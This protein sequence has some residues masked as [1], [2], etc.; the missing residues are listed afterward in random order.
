M[1]IVCT[2]EQLYDKA[3]NA[4]QMNGRMGEWVRASVGV[5]R[6]CLLSPTAFNIFLKR[7]MYNA[8]KEHD[9]KV[10]IGGFNITFTGL[11]LADNIDDVAEEEQELQVLLKVSTKPA[12]G[13]RWRSVLRR[14]Y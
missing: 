6:G 14:Q 1:Q 5:R 4:V 7:M 3:T 13:I 10:C 8:L 12:Q 2:I 9:G 11:G